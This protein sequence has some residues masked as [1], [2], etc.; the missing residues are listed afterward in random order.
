MDGVLLGQSPDIE[1]AFRPTG[2]SH[3]TAISGYNISVLVMVFYKIF[4]RFLLSRWA[5]L[6]TVLGIC[7]YALLAVT[8]S[9]IAG[10]SLWAR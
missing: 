7:L 2:A 8:E 3:I 4:D 10:P 5:A 6:L 1:T 9:P